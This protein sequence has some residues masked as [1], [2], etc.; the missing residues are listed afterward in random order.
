[1]GY[2]FN[3]DVKEIRDKAI[4]DVDDAARDKADGVKGTVTGTR[5]RRRSRSRTSARTT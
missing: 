5:H 3:V 1:M 2:A 4:L